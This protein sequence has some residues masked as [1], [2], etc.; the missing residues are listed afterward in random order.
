MMTLLPKALRLKNSAGETEGAIE[1]GGMLLGAVDWMWK[2]RRKERGRV[3]AAAATK[4]VHSFCQQRR[5]NAGG[6]RPSFQ[7]DEGH[8]YV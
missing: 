6:K 2:R 3:A 8:L 7:Q 5:R 4:I 1:R